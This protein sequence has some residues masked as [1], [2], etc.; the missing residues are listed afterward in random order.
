MRGG[1]TADQVGRRTRPRG[2]ARRHAS[3]QYLT[4]AQSR[5][6]FFRQAKGRPQDGQ[7][8]VGSGRFTSQG[9]P[10]SSLRR[11]GSTHEPG[12]RRTEFGLYS[13]GRLSTSL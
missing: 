1:S 9:S 7:V 3:L 11:Y 12:C 8:F 6:H 13:V 5:A 2:V 4:F 10:F